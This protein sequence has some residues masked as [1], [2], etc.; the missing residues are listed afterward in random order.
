M[1][2]AGSEQHPPSL[3]EQMRDDREVFTFH[4]WMRRYTDENMASQ[5]NVISN[6]DTERNSFVESFGSE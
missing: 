6:Y 2:S 3:R 5:M 4:S 1:M